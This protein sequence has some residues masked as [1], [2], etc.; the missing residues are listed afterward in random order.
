MSFDDI[1]TPEE[2]NRWL[3]EYNSTTDESLKKQLR[4]FIVLAYLPFVKRISFGLARRSTDPVEDLIQVGSLGLLK[5]L[6][7][8]DINFG[9]SFKTYAAYLITSEIRH[10]IRDKSEIIRAPRELQELSCRIN[11]IVQKLTVKQGRVPDD[12]EIAQELQI[13]VNRVME[14]NEIDNKKNLISLDNYFLESDNSDFAIADKV[15]DNKYQDFLVARDD[16][17]MLIASIKKLEPELAIIVKLSFFDD[18]T[19]AEISKYLNMSQ[20]QVSR[21]LKKALAQLFAIITQKF[22]TFNM[23]KKI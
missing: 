15:I 12:Y 1:T 3:E 18:M 9:A 23:D 7:Q 20:M 17:L 21:R 11:Q 6:D 5:A 19:Q 4:N 16:R 2:V 10:Y 13:S 8:Y 14:V 22:T